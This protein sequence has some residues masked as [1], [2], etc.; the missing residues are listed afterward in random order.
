M[1]DVEISEITTRIEIAEPSPKQVGDLH[2]IVQKVLQRLRDEQAKDEMRDAD[3]RIR[4][5]S[6]KSDVNPV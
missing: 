1:A 6:W 3:G 2:D 5:R 4:D